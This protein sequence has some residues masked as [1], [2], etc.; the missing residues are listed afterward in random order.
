MLW[1]SAAATAAAVRYRVELTLYPGDD[2]TATAQQVA[3]TYGG[4]IEEGAGVTGSVVTIELSEATARLAA[5]DPRVQSLEPVSDAEHTWTRGAYKY[6][7]SG[8]ISQVGEEDF[9]YDLNG[10]L[11]YGDAG[12][13]ENQRYTYDAFGNIL[14]IDTSER[15]AN[16]SPITTHSRLAVD[17]ATN[18][19]DKQGAEY[20]VVGTYD[21]AGNLT[22]Y[23][24]SVL[25]AYDA[26]NV[27]KEASIPG[28]T[29]R[30][31]FLYTASDER[32]ASISML[33]NTVSET[34]WTL[35]AAGGKV[36]R[37]VKKT[38]GGAWKWEQDYI[39]R[40]SELLAAEVPDERKVL[41]FHP[42]HLGTPRLIT[43]N[44]GVEVARPRYFPF[45]QDVRSTASNERMQFTGHE[46]D[47]RS[48]DY[49]HARYYD[50]MIGR[51]MSVDPEWA[52]DTPVQPQRWN[53]YAY[54]TNSPLRYV[55]PDG[56]DRWDT[57]NGYFNALFSNFGLTVR[58][59]QDNPDYQRGQ[60]AG[61]QASIGVGGVLAIAGVGGSGTLT[62]STAGVGAVTIPAGLAISA[63]GTVGALNGTQHLAESTA[64]RSGGDSPEMKTIVEEQAATKKADALKGPMKAG[65]DQVKELLSR[66]LPGH[67]QH[68]LTGDLK[69]WFAADVPGS[70]AGRGATRVIFRQD[71][72]Q[73]II[74]DI[75]NY[76]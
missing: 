20:N 74:K 6:D 53:R 47:A 43:A 17:V 35:R 21:P 52:R 37:R 13:G 14:T 16:G 61:D 65:Y 33:G 49:M 28:V 5:R 19:I 69:G 66:G 54:V 50:P 48:L 51:F 31:V 7:G 46:R 22:S 56:R 73:I 55:D 41:R 39:Y 72:D 1:I 63:I 36:L 40:G 67:N 44:G 42:D 60:R 25:L 76:H 45:G 38:A 26:L 18:Q 10:R 27:V 30:R 29:G 9:R 57:A 23:N 32:L 75:V 4:R 3:A 70:G 24:G 15:S 62:V 12:A 59:Q 71:G 58:V 34:E 11:V 68:P 2:A 8:N 64:A